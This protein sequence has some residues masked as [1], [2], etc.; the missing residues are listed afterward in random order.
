MTPAIDMI[1][2]VIEGKGSSNPEIPAQTKI[3]AEI[4]PTLIRNE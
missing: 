4:K 3:K 2:P 1:D